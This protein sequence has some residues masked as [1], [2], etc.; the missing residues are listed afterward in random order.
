MTETRTTPRAATSPAD[1]APTMR[2]PA[3]RAPADRAPWLVRA[4]NAVV[5][6]LLRLGLPMGPNVLLTVRGRTSGL[7]RTA[8]VAVSEIDGRRYVIGAYGD[9]HWVRNLRAAG[10]ATIHVGGRDVHVTAT[11]LE[12]GAARAFFAETVPGYVGRF[13]WFGRAFLRALFRLV[14]GDVL[15]NPDRAAATRPVF[16]LKLDS[17]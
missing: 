6:R 9:V 3:V 10:E 11:E 5:Q 15:T 8:P 2:A 16:E 7:P 1:G 13:P 17:P 14:A 12:P 4:P